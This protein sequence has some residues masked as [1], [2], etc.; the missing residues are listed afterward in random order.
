MVFILCFLSVSAE[1]GCTNSPN[2][3]VAIESVINENSYKEVTLWFDGTKMDDSKADGSIYKKIS[4]GRYVCLINFLE[5]DPVNVRWFG[6]KG[7]GVANDT[8][9]F[10]SA[11]SFCDKSGRDFTV[12]H[13]CYI[14]NSESINFRNKNFNVIGV[15]RPTLKYVGKG[16]A[17]IAEPTADEDYFAATRIENF[18]IE[19]NSSTT[20]GFG[21]YGYVRGSIRN[22]EVKNVSRDAFLLAG[23]VSVLFESLKFSG[24]KQDFRPEYG[25]R[26]IGHK[27]I[28]YT[29]NCT[30][31]NTIIEAYPKIG[32]NLINASGCIF[33]GG[34]FESCGTGLIISNACRLNTFENVWFED[35]SV[36]DVEIAGT[37]NLF[38]NCNF[39]SSGSEGTVIITAGKNTTFVGGYLRFVQNKNATSNTLFLGCALNENITGTLGI[40]G[41]QDYKSMGTVYVN[42]KGVPVSKLQDKFK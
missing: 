11:L 40:R 34:T 39:Q 15:G 21:I 23:C 31:I 14:L 38:K 33:T 24:A 22:I 10:I 8:K 27:S 26:M 13:G 20:V 25:I 37:S 12:P 32:V 9:P 41:H 28:D 5:G 4:H 36:K 16:R 29:S 2:K 19:G 3:N 6:A 35:N 42:D 1:I 17:F 30:F 18:I 7:D